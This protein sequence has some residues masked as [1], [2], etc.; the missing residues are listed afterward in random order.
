VSVPEIP[1]PQPPQAEHWPF[2]AEDEI[3][4]VADVLRSGKVNQWTGDRVRAFE[5]VLA[6][7]FGVGHAIA[8]ANG[9]VALEIALRAFGIGAGDEVIVTSRSFIASASSVDMVG[10]TPV[11]ADV[12]ERSQNI[13]AETIAR[14]IGPRTRAIIPVHLAGW[15]CDLPAIMT[16]A[17]KHGLLVIEDCAQS[18]GARIAGRPAGS[19]GDAAILSFCQDKI[20]TTGGEG[21]AILTDSEHTWREA[22]SYKDHGKNYDAVM[23]P[24]IG[25][26]YRWLHEQVGTN[27]R[28]TEMQAA[29]GLVQMGKLESWLGARR[30]NAEAW[31]EELSKLACLVVHKPAPGIEHAYYKLYAFVR[32]ER[33]KPGVTRD[34][35]LQALVAGGLRAFYGSCPEIYR[36]MAYADRTVERRPVAQRLGET[37]LMFEVHPTLAPE[38]VRG[39]ARRAVD[40]I[41]PYERD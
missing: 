4:A 18:I 1:Q 9:S 26:S 34:T 20:I 2:F 33:L 35:L 19:F 36:E 10:G 14:L 30:R 22:W 41:R 7:Y 29:I 39:L 21:G 6:S 16:L 40:I 25:C 37:S 32:P 23:A 27:L 15:P 17:R 24:A 12:D 3:A 8:V 11:F 13:T 38:R 31:I 5:S 28:M